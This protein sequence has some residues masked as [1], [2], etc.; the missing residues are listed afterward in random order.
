MNARI[1]Q[2]ARLSVLEI[3][4]KKDFYVALVLTGLVLAYAAQLRF[5]GIS[6]ASRYLIDLGLVTGFF[7]SVFLTVA[8]AARQFPGERRDKTLHVLLARPVTRFEY[9]LGKFWGAWLAGAIASAAF[10]T[11][12]VAVLWAKTPSFSWLLAVDTY[13]YFVLSL[14][15]L[16]ALSLLLSLFLT[17]PSTVAVTLTAYALIQ[18]YGFYWG[19]SARALGG[20]AGIASLSAYYAV[21]HFEFFDLRQRF[22]HGWPAPEP[23]LLAFLAV[24]AAAYIAL[25][26]ALAGQALKRKSLP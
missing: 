26:L 8:L 22:V 18:L 7:F 3:L 23:G 10:F 1:F 19:E 14:G 24:Y 20:V 15:I 6:T 12:L 17:P 5:Y 13:L 16:A 2:I 25:F 21:P 11:A 9:V 4:R